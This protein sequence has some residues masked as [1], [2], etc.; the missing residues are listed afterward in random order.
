MLSRFILFSFYSGILGL[1]LLESQRAEA[2]FNLFGP[3]E[4]ITQANRDTQTAY[5]IDI[6]LDGDIDI[7][8][9]S[10]ENLCWFENRLS[11]PEGDFPRRIIS[12]RD[13]ISGPSSRWRFLLPGDLDLDGDEDIVVSTRTSEGYET[14]VWF[15]NRLLEPEG[16]FGVEQ[17]ILSE[18]TILNINGS[19]FDIVDMDNDGYLDI[20]CHV[21]I[22]GQ[23]ATYTYFKSSIHGDGSVA[24]EPVDLF[25]EEIYQYNVVA[26]DFDWDGDVDFITL[27]ALEGSGGLIFFEYL[28]KDVDDEEIYPRI[29]EEEEFVPL[30]KAREFHLE[31][32]TYR[33]ILDCDLDGDGDADI[34]ACGN[35]HHDRIDWFEN[36]LN[37]P[38]SELAAPRP[39][40]TVPGG[41][42]AIYAADLDGD[43]DLDVLGLHR[44]EESLLWFEN[45]LN[46]SSADFALRGV[47]HRP[48]YKFGYTFTG[49]I[50]GDGDLDVVSEPKVG[51]DISWFENR[52]NEGFDDFERKDTNSSS[53]FRSS[54]PPIIRP[55]DLDHDGDV[56]L[57]ATSGDRNEVVWLENRLMETEEDFSNLHYIEIPDEVETLTDI[58]VG[59]LDGDN[60]PDVVLTERNRK[61]SY[62]SINRLDEPDADFSPF[63]PLPLTDLLLDQI[64]INDVDNDGDN[65]IVVFADQF[66]SVILY[67]NKINEASNDFRLVHGPDYSGTN[68][69][70]PAVGDINGD[71]KADVILPERRGAI[72]WREFPSNVGNAEPRIGV[73]SNDLVTSRSSLR[74][75]VHTID[76]DGDGDKDVIAGEYLGDVTQPATILSWYENLSHNDSTSFSEQRIINDQAPRVLSIDSEDIDGDGDIDLIVSTELDSKI[77]WH[78]NR[79]NET[80]NDF[81]PAHAIDYQLINPVSTGIADLNSDGRPDVYAMENL[82]SVIWYPNNGNGFRFLEDPGWQFVSPPTLSTPDASFEEDEKALTITTKTNVKDF[83][84]WDSPLTEV[85]PNPNQDKLLT[86]T[87][88]TRTKVDPP[89]YVPNVNMRAST[90]DFSRSDIIVTTSTGTGLFSP[91]HYTTE[92]TQLIGQP[93]GVDN[94]RFAFEVLNVFPDDAL[95]AE[96]LLSSLQFEQQDLAS[97]GAGTILLNQDFVATH[98]TNFGWTAFTPITGTLT[99][100]EEY[101]DSNGLSIRGLVPSQVP[102]PFLPDFIFGNWNYNSNIIL[103]E[104]RVYQVR[105]VVTSDVAV[106]RR[107]T[108]PAF[109]LRVNTSSLM[110]SN[111]VN[112]ESVNPTANVPVNGE[113]KVYDLW[114]TV[115]KRISGDT[116]NLAFDYLYVNKGTIDPDDPY[117]SISLNRIQVNEY[118]P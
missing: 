108:L 46:E 77:F 74:R 91:R 29:L 28:N 101:S 64:Q 87:W 33:T 45:R 65:D 26:D 110:S 117:A 111:L 88:Q 23:P 43:S 9:A 5:P 118:T 40:A 8:S 52:I 85:D 58:E 105:F 80:T 48:I 61:M 7:V 73:I 21:Y 24:F 67:E 14:I 63:I 51:P 31:A 27:G 106:N 86:A 50:D 107:A 104:G 97:L 109:R 4:E 89:R 42:S 59:D 68:S 12:S 78:E 90:E 71:L 98:G 19:A 47:V 102:N 115:D 39:V 16:D 38:V 11:E 44:D 6:D 37:E 99:V 2:Q 10:N 93:A 116:L 84:F 112:I 20:L 41:F 70:H 25:E 34:L 13:P 36:K 81:S 79:L 57:I 66:G 114:F 49:D 3:P 30:V 96:I 72:R 60:V 62:Y 22:F 75:R 92:Y 82:S 100:P 76:L 95:N 53:L 18:D 32:A 94:Y 1:S 55:G 113:E 54:F 35:R 103:K 15:E 83:G 17:N 56:D 69:G